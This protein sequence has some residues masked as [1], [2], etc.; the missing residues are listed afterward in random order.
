MTASYEFQLVGE[1]EATT[2]SAS[3]ISLSFTYSDFDEFFV[4]AKLR[5]TQT[6]AGNHSI[7]S[8]NTFTTFNKFHT[9]F[10]FIIS[11]HKKNV[12]NIDNKH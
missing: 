2:N 5:T 8:S 12:D 3:S 10:L 1:T 9:S 11:I 6:T 7:H 4:T